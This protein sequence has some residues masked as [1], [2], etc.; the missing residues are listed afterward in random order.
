MARSPDRRP[1]ARSSGGG[2]VA[3]R[4]ALSALT[5]LTLIVGACFLLEPLLERL[6]GHGPDEPFPSAVNPITR[7]PVGWFSVVQGNGP[8]T[9][10]TLLLLGGD[11][12]LGRDEFLRLL[13]GGQVSLEIAFIA[14]AIALIIGVFFGTVAGYYGGLRSMPR[15]AGSRSSSCRSRCCCW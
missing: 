3:T 5:G 10:K 1:A 8:H 11:G 9:G 7:Q 4:S 2:S 13:A 15:S 12:P 14:T 6:L